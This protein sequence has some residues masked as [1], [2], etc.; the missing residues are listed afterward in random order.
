MKISIG[1]DHAGYELKEAVK[2]HISYQGHEVLDQGTLST[3][4][5]DYPD[6]AVKV[7][8]DVAAKKATFGVLVCG[9]GIGMA[10]TANKVHGIR[11]ANITSELEAQLFREHNDG[12]VIAIGA[13]ILKE[14]AAYTIVDRFLATA[15]SQGRHIQ[16][17]EKIAKVEQ[18]ES[19]S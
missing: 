16:R 3:A 14:D 4:S 19:A 8:H 13:R 18:A 15:F 7:A 1:S 11:A 10:I 17:V 2:K 6:Y 12:N 9:S 5:V